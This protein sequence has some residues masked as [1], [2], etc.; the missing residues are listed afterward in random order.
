MRFN[1][2]SYDSVR[3]S[4]QGICLQPPT[5]STAPNGASSSRNEPLQVAA[6]QL[7]PT[8][9]RTREQPG[10]EHQ[11][12]KEDQQ[13]ERTRF[14]ASMWSLSADVSEPSKCVHVVEKILTRSDEIV[15]KQRDHQV[16]PVRRATAAAAPEPVTA[17]RTSHAR[18]RL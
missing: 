12:H 9:R 17:P 8:N 3:P 1:S 10:Y 2:P 18:P 13:L 7:P 11:R 4:N 15:D 16:V 6:G 14:M 5:E